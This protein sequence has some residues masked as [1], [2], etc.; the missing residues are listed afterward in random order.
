MIASVLAIFKLLE[1][2]AK[3][4]HR[5]PSYQCALAIFAL[6]FFMLATAIGLVGFT[7]VPVGGMVAPA[8]LP[9]WTWT[10]FVTLVVG[11]IVEIS[12]AT[13]DMSGTGGRYLF[14][15]R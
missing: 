10:I 6:L 5:A 9:R 2:M 14:G 12:T 11:F 7:Y 13:T 1:L 8:A 4:F 3:G 15:G